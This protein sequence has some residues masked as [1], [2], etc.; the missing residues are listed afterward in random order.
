MKTV[1]SGEKV[2]QIFW[3]EKTYTEQSLDKL[4]KVKYNNNN[5]NIYIYIREFSDCICQTRQTLDR[6]IEKGNEEFFSSLDL[7]KNQNQDKI[8]VQTSGRMNPLIE[9]RN[10][11]N[12]MENELG[13]TSQSPFLSFAS[14]IENINNEDRLSKLK[15]YQEIFG[16]KDVKDQKIKIS[17]NFN[18]PTLG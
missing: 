7:N 17:E 14:E 18:C 6:S 2:I 3:D 10:E 9:I 8:L 5:N 12:V 13:L 15:K 1:K 16:Q 11:M 4:A